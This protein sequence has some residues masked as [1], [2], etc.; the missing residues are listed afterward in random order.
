ML[1]T[2]LSRLG[3][4]VLLLFLQVMIFNHIHIL[5]YATPMPYVY[6]LLI[7][8]S[9]TP[10]WFYIVAGFV[11]GLAAD[12]FTNTPGMAAAS[13]CACGLVAPQLLMSLAPSDKDTDELRPSARTMKWSGFLGYAFC[14]T[15]LHC[16]LYFTIEAFSLSDWQTLL[17]NIGASTAITFLLIAAFEMLR[18][19]KR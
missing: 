4:F 17:I 6:F 11:L 3:W 8:S 15:L 12:L 1:Q 10:R 7:L 18:S 2:Y 19:R 5:G 9:E 16:L 14:L 13:L